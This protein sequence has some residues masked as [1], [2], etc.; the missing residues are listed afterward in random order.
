MDFENGDRADQTFGLDLIVTVGARERVS[1]ER[2]LMRD[3]TL[4]SRDRLCVLKYLAFSTSMFLIG[5]L[6]LLLTLVR[7]HWNLF[8]IRG[9]CVVC[10]AFMRLCSLCR[11]SM[12]VYSSLKRIGVT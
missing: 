4:D 10:R 6:S 7:A 11:P 12:R 8:H 3:I 1:C 2:L 5:H 9:V